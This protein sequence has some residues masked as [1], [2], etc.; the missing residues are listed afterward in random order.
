MRKAKRKQLEIVSGSPGPSAPDNRVFCRFVV[1]NIPFRF[2]D[3]KLG[4]KGS[5]LCKDISGG[6]AGLEYSGEI[7]PR[8]PVEMW[9]EFP[10][11]QEPLHLLGKVEWNRNQ[12]ASW[13]M[14]VSFDRQRLLSLGRILKSPG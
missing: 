5:G 8:T 13:R 1:D 10:D 4:K 14:G 12:G 7:K 3:L 2:K 9:F 6:G 11:G